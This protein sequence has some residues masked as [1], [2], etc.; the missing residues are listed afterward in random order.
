LKD[1]TPRLYLIA[2]RVALLALLAL[3][4]S[5]ATLAAAPASLGAQVVPDTGS[6]VFELEPEHCDNV[7]AAIER[8]IRPMNFIRPHM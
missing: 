1:P 8:T 6:M 5:A 7:Q 2:M 3:L 4:V